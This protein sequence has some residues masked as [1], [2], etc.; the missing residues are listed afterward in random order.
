MFPRFF[1]TSLPQTSFQILTIYYPLPPHEALVAITT[2]FI[3]FLPTFAVDIVLLL[4]MLAVYPY[5]S[6]QKSRF[7]AIFALPVVLKIARI[8]GI[9]CVSVKLSVTLR[10]YIYTMNRQGQVWSIALWVMNG[11][12]NAWEIFNRSPFYL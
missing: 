2:G 7:A 11:V 3:N 4:R 8:V 9:I 12:D 6:T 1:S 10:V 5:S